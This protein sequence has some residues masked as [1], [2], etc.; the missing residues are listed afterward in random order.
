MSDQ[1]S[2]ETALLRTSGPRP[3]LRVEQE[4][5][6]SFWPK[7]SPHVKAS[8]VGDAADETHFGYSSCSTQAA[9]TP[10]AV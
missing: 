1:A 3:D 4:G 5:R 9:S 2:Y 6:S 7:R 10:R 8:S